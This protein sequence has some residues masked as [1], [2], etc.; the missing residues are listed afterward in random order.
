MYVILKFTYEYLVSYNSQ[1]VN[2]RY[3]MFIFNLSSAY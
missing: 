2:V 3:N 1:S